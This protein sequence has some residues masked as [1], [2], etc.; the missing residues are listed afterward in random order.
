MKK[1]DYMQFFDDNAHRAAIH[2]ETFRKRVMN[3]KMTWEDALTIPSQKN[4]R[5]KEFYEYRELAIKKGIKKKTFDQRIDTY[6][7]SYKE[8]LETN[9]KKRYKI[10]NRKQLD[11]AASYEIPWRILK[12]YMETKSLTTQEALEYAIKNYRPRK[13]EVNFD[14]TDEIKMLLRAGLPIKKKKYV[15]FIKNHPDLFE[16]VM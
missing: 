16:E 1:K 15:E 3:K 4:K 13:K 2:R 11:I 14:I 8:A 6:G 7:M 9:V 10:F 5:Q 12:Y